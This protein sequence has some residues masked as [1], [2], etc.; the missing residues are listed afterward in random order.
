MNSDATEGNLS[1]PEATPARES[2]RRKRES[3]FWNSH[4][5]FTFVV[6]S[7]VLPFR[8][9]SFLAFLGLFS[10]FS[11]FFF[12]FLSFSSSS[13][14]AKISSITYREDQKRSWHLTH[15]DQEEDCFPILLG[16]NP[17]GSSHLPW[18]AFVRR[19][20]LFPLGGGMVGGQTPLSTATHFSG[21]C[22]H[23]RRGHAFPSP[24]VQQDM[25]VLSHF[26]S[27]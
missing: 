13:W 26:K 24:S 19:S 10:F 16:S 7:F 8:S 27:K 2:G 5:A 15:H 14:L 17:A 9:F 4:T 20:C 11:S 6:F 23:T 18:G 12:F 3:D 22:F 25:S 1:S 21:G